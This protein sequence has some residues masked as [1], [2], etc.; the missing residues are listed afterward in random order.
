MRTFINETKIW[1]RLS[2][3]FFYSYWL[4]YPA[5]DFAVKRNEPW[6]GFGALVLLLIPAWPLL[7]TLGVSRETNTSFKSG[8]A[9]SPVGLI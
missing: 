8:E 3:V 1:T 2:I 4:L 7:D 6:I 5:L 9:K